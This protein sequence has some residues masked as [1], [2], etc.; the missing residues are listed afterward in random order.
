MMKL[1]YDGKLEFITPAFLCGANQGRAEL[2]PASF[3]GALRWWFRVLGGTREEEL[4]VFG[5]VAGSATASKIVVRTQMLD[6]KHEHFAP[7][8][9]NTSRGYLYYFAE[10][11]GENKGIR[12]GRNAYFAQGTLFRLIVLQRAEFCGREKE[13]LDRALAAFLLFGTL[14][15]RSTRGCGACAEPDGLLT[16][17]EVQER[18]LGLKRWNVIAKTVSDEVYPTALKAQEALGAYLRNF[19]DTNHLSG[20]GSSALGYS[21]GSRRSSSALRLRPVRIKEGFLAVVVYTDAA[22]G[23]T[24]VACLL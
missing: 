14:G 9:Q 1:L 16:K 6:E 13:L 4:S 22:C 17:A 18:L 21:T 15:L 24:S 7:T 3:R 2:R 19:R 12:V 11:S 23:E 8:V 20:K 5:G 10:V